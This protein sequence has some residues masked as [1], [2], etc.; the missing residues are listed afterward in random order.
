MDAWNGKTAAGKSSVS[1]P[2]SLHWTQ[3]VT[4][5]ADRKV[6]TS[7][8]PLMWKCGTAACWEDTNSSSHIYGEKTGYHHE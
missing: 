1:L 8:S 6:Y 3:A 7:G 5:A 2:R 4:T